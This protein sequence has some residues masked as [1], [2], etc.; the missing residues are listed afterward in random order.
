MKQTKK[1]KLQKQL[2]FLVWTAKQRQQNKKQNAC[3]IFSFLSK[4]V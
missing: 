1:K 4:Q 2:F 3:F